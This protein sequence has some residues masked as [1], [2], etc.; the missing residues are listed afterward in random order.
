MSL[1]PR[2][3]LGALDLTEHPFAVEFGG[4][5]GDPDSVAEVINSLLAD[6]EL[7]LSSRRG[8]RTMTFPVLIDDSDLL[9]LAEAET[10]LTAECDKQ[11][12]TFSI[13]PGD[14]IAPV[15]VFDTFRA[16]ARFKRSDDE[17]QAGVR[18]YELSFRALPFG[19]STGKFLD[20]ASSP[21]GAS[22]GTLVNN[23]QS[24]TGWASFG[25][26]LTPSFA[27]DSTVFTEGAGSIKSWVTQ[28][29]PGSDGGSG[30]QSNGAGG[31]QTYHSY[32][33][34][35]GFGRDQITGLSVATGT[36]GYMSVAIRFD[37][38][39][40]AS[41]LSRLWQSTTAGVW[42]EVVAFAAVSVDSNGFVRYRWA[43]AASQTILGLRF[44]TTHGTQSLQFGVAR[45]YVWFDDFRLLPTTSTEQQ[46]VKQLKVEG[47]V[48][49][50]GSLHIG[51]GTDSVPLGQV[52]VVTM[53]TDV[54]PAGFNPEGRA[55]VT[56]GTV[57]SD[58]TALNGSYYSPDA[59]TYSSAAGKP[60]FDVPVSMLTA[61]AYTM[62]TLVKTSAGTVTTGVQAQ[63]NVN[64]T[65]TGPTSAAEVSVPS[66]TT[67][68]QF[69]TVGTIYLP[70]MPV[71]GAAATTKVRLL[72]KGAVMANV[73]MIPAWQVGGSPV[74]DFSIVD[75][76]TGGA[77]ASGASSHLW[78]DSPDTDQPQGGWWRGPTADRLNT[79]SA[80]PA[81]KKP[82][83]HTF[84]PGEL[85]AFLVTTGAQGPTLALEYFPRWANA[86]A[87]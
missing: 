46:I 35:G 82:G 67:A 60:I 37:A 26:S 70:P 34:N 21:P 44:E 42:E 41:R 85:S 72:F 9:A 24:T 29:E 51:S 7:E 68:W 32:T 39:Y 73:Y 75:C 13:D 66:T 16:S 63:L 8:N 1:N 58:V 52:L 47:S 79:R 6:G 56:Q 61:G 18:R 57:T 4:D 5:M 76:G 69:V 11:R 30:T 38:F 40:D 48:R 28:W 77:S 54:A 50:T 14:G 17:E 45:P 80:W 59:A 81:A 64:G 31:T 86:A 36:G 74:A 65:L 22:A 83:I 27:V 15:T 3:I 87:L 19:R 55:H 71:Q 25:G 12:N 43:V 23:C 2:F 10:L 84:R 33:A 53:P 49:T 20:V 62:V 78:I